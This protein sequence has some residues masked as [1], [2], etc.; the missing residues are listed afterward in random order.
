M[1]WHFPKWPICLAHVSPGKDPM[2]EM[3]Q[4][5]LQAIDKKKRN[6]HKVY[7]FNRMDLEGLK[8]DVSNISPINENW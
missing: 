3:Y 8:R 6:G 2:K 5:E 7:M 1:L 4:F